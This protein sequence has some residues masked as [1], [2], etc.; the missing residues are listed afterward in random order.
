MKDQQSE[1]RSRE[2]EIDSLNTMHLTSRAKID[3]LV[4]VVKD[5]GLE[6]EAELTDD[7]MRDLRDVLNAHETRAVGTNKRIDLVAKEL[8]AIRDHWED[9]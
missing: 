5:A 6:A 2:D 4:K 1:I 8:R 9:Y 3:R 7:D